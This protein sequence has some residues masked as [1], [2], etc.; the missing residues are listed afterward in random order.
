MV[1]SYYFL[2]NILN[3]A[4]SL[5]KQCF[6]KYFEFFVKVNSERSHHSLSD[7]MKSIN[8]MIGRARVNLKAISLEFGERLSAWLG[9][10][11]DLSLRRLDFD[12]QLKLLS[13]EQSKLNLQKLLSFGESDDPSLESRT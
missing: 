2:I 6:A 10:K 13:D 12:A 4:I 11:E 7:C 3:T 1:K 9:V 8:L 5:E